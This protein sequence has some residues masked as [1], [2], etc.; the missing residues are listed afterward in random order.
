MNSGA[1]EELLGSGDTGTL[2]MVLQAQA[3]V[4]SDSDETLVSEVPLVDVP[5]PD[6]SF[7]MYFQHKS[8][9]VIVQQK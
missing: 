2:L 3:Q 5:G 4:I 1:L 6:T 8:G 7:Y 9:Q